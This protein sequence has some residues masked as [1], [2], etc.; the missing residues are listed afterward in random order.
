MPEATGVW[1]TIICEYHV[2]S[3]VYFAPD[4]PHSAESAEPKGEC[5][6]AAQRIL[7]AKGVS[8]SDSVRLG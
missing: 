7:D 1:T 5:L 3:A 2:G 8:D 4:A 6:A